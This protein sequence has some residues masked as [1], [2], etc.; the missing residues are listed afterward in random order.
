MGFVNAEN[1][2]NA[3]NDL[4]HTMEFIGMVLSQG[5]VLAKYHHARQRV[6]IKHL[7]YLSDQSRKAP[8]S[9]NESS[10]GFTSYKQ[11]YIAR[12]YGRL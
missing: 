7:E 5:V 11:K 10:Q 9:Q 8:Q 6:K 12:R 2:T 1:Q 3:A 4:A